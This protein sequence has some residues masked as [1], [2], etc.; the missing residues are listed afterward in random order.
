M[1]DRY[2]IS[3][4]PKKRASSLQSQLTTM[5]ENFAT[6]LL[7]TL[8]KK[9]VADLADMRK[10]LVRKAERKRVIPRLKSLKE[11]PLLPAPSKTIPT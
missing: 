9:R 1:Q 11:P 7:Q 5:A 2:I 6:E 10:R 4:E 8:L 3:L